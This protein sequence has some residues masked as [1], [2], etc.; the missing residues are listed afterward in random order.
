MLRWRA[1]WLY[2]NS[3][4]VPGT[5]FARWMQRMFHPRAPR[6]G[7]PLAGMAHG[8]NGSNGPN[9]SNGSAAELLPLGGD[10]PVSPPPGGGASRGAVPAAV[11]RVAAEY[12]ARLEAEAE[13]GSEWE[14]AVDSGAHAAPEGCG[15]AHDLLCRRRVHVHAGHHLWQDAVR[16][17]R[18]RSEIFGTS[19]LVGWMN[20][21]SH[22]CDLDASRRADSLRA[23]ALG[24]DAPRARPGPRPEGRGARAPGARPG[25]LPGRRRRARG[26]GSCARRE[27]SAATWCASAARCSSR[28]HALLNLPAP[29]PLACRLLKL[30]FCEAD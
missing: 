7:G 30:V 2:A 19:E 27:T 26:E 10:L 21:W 9:I 6:V 12:V 24:P 5:G 20:H 8:S 15:E 17:A 1:S 18:A 13:E 11:R 22:S 23:P 3:G 4:A 14:L 29:T 28:A 16:P 25:R